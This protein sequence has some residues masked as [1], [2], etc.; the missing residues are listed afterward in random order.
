MTLFIFASSAMRFFLF[1]SLPAVSQMTTST[2]LAF[3]ALQPS[4]M[5]AEGS[6]PS[7]CL[8][9]GTPTRSLQIVSCSDA[10]ARNVSA[11]TRSTDFP[12][13]LSMW[14]SF[15]MDVVLPTP[16]TPIIMMNSGVSWHSCRRSPLSSIF[17]TISLIWVRTASASR[18]R[19]CRM[20]SRRDS[21][22]FTVVSMPMSEEIRTSSS[23][24][25]I[26]SS[27][28]GRISSTSSMRSVMRP[29]KDFFLIDIKTVS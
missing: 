15:A 5:T 6:A 1:C 19:S 23:S 29:K 25:S 27:G 14:A 8:M 24:S 12:S 18:R 22:I 7:L 9:M 11:A 21:M 28:L 16:L 2:P 17:P 13:F 3:A 20:L 10:A 26:S 4:K